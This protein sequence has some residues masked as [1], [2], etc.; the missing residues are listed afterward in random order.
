MA[1]WK[2][3]GTHQRLAILDIKLA[4]I[5]STMEKADQRIDTACQAI[6]QHAEDA[7]QEVRLIREAGIKRGG[8]L[9]QLLGNYQWLKRAGTALL[10]AALIGLGGFAWDRLL[11]KS[12]PIIEYK[13]DRLLQHLEQQKGTP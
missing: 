8:Q 7:K 1:W 5:V 2:E 11:R 13:L 4:A 12:P 3:N 9:D 10:L 6:K